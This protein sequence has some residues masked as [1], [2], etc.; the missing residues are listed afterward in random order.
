MNKCFTVIKIIYGQSLLLNESTEL[1]MWW[2]T[3]VSLLLITSHHACK[4]LDVLRCNSRHNSKN[5]IRNSTLFFFFYLKAYAKV[6]SSVYMGMHAELWMRFKIWICQNGLLLYTA[7]RNN[8]S[9]IFS[10]K[11]AIL[12]FN[13][14]DLSDSL[15]TTFF[16]YLIKRNFF[17]RSQESLMNWL[18]T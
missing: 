1:L 16:K 11:F 4:V 12:Y 5:C 2:K 9:V 18:K 15:V 8:T 14:F 7:V 17:L 3:F 6:C 13:F 10:N